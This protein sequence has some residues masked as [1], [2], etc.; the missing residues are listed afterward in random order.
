LFSCD[1]QDSRFAKVKEWPAWSDHQRSQM[2]RFR[3]QII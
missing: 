2:S 1:W 3:A